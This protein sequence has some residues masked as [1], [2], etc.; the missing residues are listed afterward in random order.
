MQN[1]KQH[2]PSNSNINTR[3]AYKAGLMAGRNRA[4]PVNPYN[5]EDDFDNYTSWE[6]GYMAGYPEHLK[7]VIK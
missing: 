6:E 7:I 1:N 3:E 5:D 2:R 4:Y